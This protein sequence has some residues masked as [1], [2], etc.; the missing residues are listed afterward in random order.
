[1]AV[2]GTEAVWDAGKGTGH[3]EMAV[4]LISRCMRHARPL[5][6]GTAGMVSQMCGVSRQRCAQQECL[7]SRCVYVESVYRLLQGGAQLNTG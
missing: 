2:A 3:P 1:M 6:V 5:Q 7:W 4:T